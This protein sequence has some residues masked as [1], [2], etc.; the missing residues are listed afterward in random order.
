[1]APQGK[2]GITVRTSLH[3]E[4]AFVS[5]MAYT[6]L[7][8][9]V[10]TELVWSEYDGGGNWETGKL[11]RRRSA[12]NGRTWTTLDDADASGPL[13]RST[14]PR[15]K[16][17]VTRSSAGMFCLPDPGILVELVQ[18]LEAAV[19]EEMSFGPD[20]AT[21]ERLQFRTGR[22][23]Y[24][25]SRDEGTSWSEL[26]QVI[27]RGGG[28]DSTHWANGL[29]YGKNACFLTALTVPIQAPDGAFLVPVYYYRLDEQGA[30]IKWPDRFG[31]VIW[32]ISAAACLR[33]E[34]NAARGDLEWEMSSPVTAPEYITHGLDECEIAVVDH[35]KLMMIMRGCAAAWQAFSGVKFFATSRDGGRTWGPPVP[36]TYPDGSFVHSP[37]CLP[38]L[39]RSAKNGR[40]YVIANIVS[41][42]CR[43]SDPR[44]PLAIAEVDPQYYWVLPE[45]V[46]VI[47]DRLPRHPK[48]VRFSN[49]QR[50][51]D[52]E[53]GNPVIFMTETRYDSIIPDTQGTLLPHA[54]RYELQ[55]PTS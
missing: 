41:G 23:F 2:T 10:L 20:A 47:A 45:T 49:W 40:L 44:Y 50:I 19:N 21:Q 8:K 25:L 48:G 55:L 31:D 4:H 26:R 6:S 1:M 51:E 39:F 36:L 54:Y 33:G 12:D 42:P 52:R 15:G 43:Q 3:L 53:T 37:A 11:L 32:P 7:K 5:G 27:Q 22:V 16:R 24:R 14:E 9:P 38:N 29:W 35:G 34:W 28:Y 18:E 30:L 46:T 17:T 13:V